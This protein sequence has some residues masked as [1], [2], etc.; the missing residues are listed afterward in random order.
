MNFHIN[1]SKKQ[2]AILKSEQL[3][4]EKRKDDKHAKRCLSILM[5][6]MFKSLSE[7]SLLLNVSTDTIQ[8]WLSG[9]LLK[10]ISGI[11]RKQS[12]GRPPKLTGKQKKK[13]VAM[14]S[15]GPEAS[16]FPGGCWRT[17]MIQTLIKNKFNVHYAV[18]YVSELLHSLGLSYQKATSVSPNRDEIERSNWLNNVWPK[19]L[20]KSE[21]LNA[22]ILFGDEASFS[23]SGTLSY[24]WAPVGQQPVIKSSGSRKSYK[25]FGLIDYFTGNFYHQGYD[26]M[27]NSE[28]YQEFLEEVLSKTRKHIILVQDNAPYHTSNSMQEF[29]RKHRS[30]ITVYALPKCSPDYNPIEKIW[31]KIKQAGTHLKY[32]P[33][34]DCL[35]DKVQDMLELMGEVKDEV[36]SLFG[37]YHRLTTA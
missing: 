9:F 18:K 32:F 35:M 2:I 28:S 6:A 26:G 27:L 22:H 25:V 16:G 30:R 10:G 19:I 20:K 3:K 34:Y 24:T 7:V 11:A 37:F 17:P 12:P 21:K 5:L 15:S 1:L 14:I 4:F 23:Q 13:L 33:T 29:F 8:R 31:K 36:L